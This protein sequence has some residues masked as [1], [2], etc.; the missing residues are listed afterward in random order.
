MQLSRGESLED[1]GAGALALPRRARDPHALA[2]RA[3]G[4]GRGGVDP[5]DQRADRGRAPVPGAR[6]RADDPRAARRRST[7]CAIAWVGDGTNVLVSLAQLAKLRRDGGRRRVPGGLRPA[8]RNAARARARPARGGRGR[9]R[10][11]HRHLGL[12]R[13]GGDAR[14][15]GCATSSRTASTRRCSRSPSPDAI[16]LHCLPAHPG[17]EITP[18]AL[19][20]EQSAV[21]DEAENRLHVQKALLALLLG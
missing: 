14:A 8:G 5:G 17:E 16:V 6:R 1:T 7:A 2:R 4:V 18:E 9:R 19:Y 20:G 15:S 21:W 11:R 13:P 3:R 10:P 12:A